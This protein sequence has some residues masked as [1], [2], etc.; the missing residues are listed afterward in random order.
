ML[1][2]GIRRALMY[3]ARLAAITFLLFALLSLVPD[4]SVM[5]LG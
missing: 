3:A 4:Y 1:R 2:Y 5:I